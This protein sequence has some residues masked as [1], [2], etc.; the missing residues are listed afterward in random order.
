MAHLSQARVPDAQWVSELF[1]QHGD[2]QYLR[3]L[4]FS[5]TLDVIS[6]VALES[7]PWASGCDQVHGQGAWAFISIV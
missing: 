2:A 7:S 1:E 4:L 6:F 5:A 3:D